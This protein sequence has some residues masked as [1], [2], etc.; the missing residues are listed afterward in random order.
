MT[1]VTTKTALLI[2]NSRSG[3]ADADVDRAVD[4][5]ERSGIDVAL[6]CPGDPAEIDG[7]I[8]QAA[9]TADMIILAG[10]DGTLS[11]SVGAV[12]MADRPLGILPMGTAN[13]FARALG[14]PDDPEQAA[15]IIS[16]GNIRNVDVGM[17]DDRPFLNVASVGFSVE[18]ARFHS[19]DRKK[20]LRLLS[21]PLSWMDAYQRH[22]PFAARIVCDGVARTRRCTQ[23]AVGSGR[24]YGGGLMLSEQAQI[25]DG[26]LRVYSVEPLGFWGWVRLLPSFRFG[27]LG[28]KKEAELLRAKAVD[29]ETRQPRSINVD[30]EL[31]GRTPARFRIR[32]GALA[33]FAPPTP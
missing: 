26:W 20:R 2:L 14:L 22:R 29:I 18:V 30:G 31:I 21:Y 6:S 27:T 5:L 10:G 9:P 15:A 17:I 7:L 33:V 4:H 28:K 11:H 13:D 23:L 24:H 19:G 12:L 16:D 8:A 3:S 32:P 1:T 25:D